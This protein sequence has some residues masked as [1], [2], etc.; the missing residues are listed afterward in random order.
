MSTSKVS[1]T[2]DRAA[3]LDRSVGGR[4]TGETDFMSTTDQCALCAGVL[5]AGLCRVFLPARYN[6][7]VAYELGI[8]SEVLIQRLADKDVEILK[9]RN[10]LEEAGKQLHE[11]A[12]DIFEWGLRLSS[13]ERRAHGLDQDVRYYER[14]ARGVRE[15]LKTPNA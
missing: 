8:E 13:E 7:W 2:P 11:A 14:A 12:G 5:H 6:R 3:P 15:A 10:A 4:R 9:L 1:G